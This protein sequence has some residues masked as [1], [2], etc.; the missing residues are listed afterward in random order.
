MGFTLSDFLAVL[1]VFPVPL[2][3]AGRSDGGVPCCNRLRGIANGGLDVG[4]CPC[5]FGCPCPDLGLSA[6][7]V[8]LFCRYYSVASA[9]RRK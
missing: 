2:L 9:T 4:V 3:S 5:V 7:V 1:P 6:C 8:L